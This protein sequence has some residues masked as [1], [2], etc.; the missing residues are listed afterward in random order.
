MGMLPELRVS[1]FLSRNLVQLYTTSPAKWS[2]RKSPPEDRL[3]QPKC[4]FLV[5][6]LRSFAQNV[7]SVACARMSEAPIS[8]QV[9]KYD[10]TAG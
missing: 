5:R 6:L 9:C 8:Q 7:A 10:L 2:T 3:S 4:E 1:R